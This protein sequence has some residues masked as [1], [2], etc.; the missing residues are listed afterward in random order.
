MINADVVVIGAG[1]GGYVAAIRSAQLGK[2][3]VLIEKLPRLGGE[4]LNWGCIPSKALINAADLYHHVQNANRMGITANDVSMDIQKLIGWKNEVV[5][6]LTSGI[7]SLCEGQGIQVVHGKA[8]FATENEIVVGSSNGEEIKI[9]V[10]NVIISVGTDFIEL[11][12]L[13]TDHPRVFNA[14]SLLD[15]DYIPKHLVIIGG[16]V[17]GLELGTVFSK[18][19][20]KVTVVELL[21]QIL[22]GMDKAIVAVLKRSLTKRFGFDIHVKSQATGIEHGNESSIVKVKTPKG[23]LEL[24]CDAVLVSVGKRAD[25]QDLLGLAK[26]GVKIDERGFI[27]V[28]NQQRTTV[29]SIF[30]IGDCTGMPFLAH[31]ASH[32]GIVAAEVIA[33]KDSKYDYEYIPSAI[34]TD[35]EIATAGMTE[36]DAKQKGIEI[37]KAKVPFSA[38]GRAVAVGDTQGYAKIISRKDSGAIIGVQIVGPHACDLISEGTLAIELGV[39]VNK[40]ATMIHPH[41]T[42]SEILMETADAVLGHAIHFQKLSL[43]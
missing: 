11:P 30:A 16:G 6:T 28:D 40:I 1:P 41:P 38:I 35:P 37:A 26:I 32:Q 36:S 10:E 23:E 42:F 24:D 18:L 27:Q 13:K 33:G 19:G 20:S 5:S 12:F 21:N 8:S 17:I 7:A 39:P 34:F 29:P 31:K 22:P 14:K 15:I 25:R 43:K 2:K 3:V 9:N 4:C